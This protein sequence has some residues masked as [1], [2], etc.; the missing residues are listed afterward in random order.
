LNGLLKKE[1]IFL[2][3]FSMILFRV[4]LDLAIINSFDRMY[5]LSSDLTLNIEA[6][7]YIISLIVFLFLAINAAYIIKRKTISSIILFFIFLLSYVPGTALYGLV[8]LPDQYFLY[9]NIYWFLLV[10]CSRII[11][12]ISIPRLNIVGKSNMPFYLIVILSCLTAIWISYKI[13][14]F[15]LTISLSGSNVNTLRSETYEM[16]TGIYAY[17]IYWIGN[18]VIPFA[19]VHFFIKKKWI[20]LSAVIFVQIVLFSI[21]GTK[22]WLFLIPVSI[23]GVLFYKD[24]LVK[25]VSAAFAFVNFIGTWI[26]HSFGIEFLTNM[27]TRRVFVSQAMNNYFYYDFF[28]DNE[29]DYLTSSIFR[30]FGAKSS[31]TMPIA[32]I[33]ADVYYYEDSYA[34]SGFFADAYS[35]F[36]V[37]GLFLYPFFLVLFFRMYEGIAKGIETKHIISI[38]IVSS[39]YLLNGSFFT[40]FL[41]FGLFA[42]MVVMLIYPRNNIAGERI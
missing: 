8:G 24:A 29:K 18:I 15:R 35:N 21:N 39:V 17:V 20:P 41:T 34:S 4:S 14:G 40:V 33:I 6:Y 10:F 1:N 13:T 16:I 19:I 30:W 37:S 27:I 23:L 38:L 9:F 26:Y 32:K 12:R 28:V 25:Y 2:A 11:P 31:Y 7:K 5:R 22:T 3:V 42:G 36:G